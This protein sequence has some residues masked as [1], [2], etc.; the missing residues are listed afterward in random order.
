M[1]ALGGG[2]G[3]G[4]EGMGTERRPSCFEFK[5]SVIPIIR[6]TIFNKA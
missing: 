2:A 4:R 3:G 6:F 1:C 5:F